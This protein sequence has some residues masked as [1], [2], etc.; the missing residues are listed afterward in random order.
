MYKKDKMAQRRGK[1]MTYKIAFFDIDGTIL[2]PNHIIQQSTK[3]AIKQLQEKGIEVVIATGRTIVDTLDVAKQLNVDSFLTFNGAYGIRKGKEL[4]T[5]SFPR[6]LVE[7]VLQEGQ[8]EQFDVLVLTKEGTS[9]STYEAERVRHF[10]KRLH[11]DIFELSEKHKEETLGMTI[12]LDRNYQ[13]NHEELSLVKCNIDIDFS[14]DLLLKE[15]NKGTAVERYLKEIG[16]DKSE[17]FAIGDGMNDKEMLAYVGMGVAM[18]NA[19]KDLHPYANYITT[20]V[21]EDGIFN[22]L[23]KAEMI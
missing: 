17:A 15:V 8:K 11:M 12:L 5:T 9:T 3:D 10:S 22:A 4:F 18:G 19:S 1:N 16:V 20:S 21:E 13:N 23:K 14:Y 6:P 2:P 7:K